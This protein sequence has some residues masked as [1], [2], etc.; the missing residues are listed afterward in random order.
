VAGGCAA[1]S[2]TP[3]KRFAGGSIA[4]P[5]G[6]SLLE[7]RNLDTPVAT[8]ALV[9]R[10]T[11]LRIG[12]SCGSVFGADPAS[13]VFAEPASL[14]V[15]N[16]TL[17]WS[18]SSGTGSFRKVTSLAK[19]RILK[20]RKLYI[21]FPNGGPTNFVAKVNSEEEFAEVERVVATFESKYL[22]RDSGCAQTPR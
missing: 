20:E 2:E 11:G 5:Q 9:N 8:G 18:K 19:D 21:S 22:K 3:R 6:Y 17:I 14:K 1:I 7:D 10:E 15:R 4:L 12:Y 13:S 16:Y